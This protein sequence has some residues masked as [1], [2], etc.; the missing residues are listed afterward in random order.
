MSGN[1]F[2]I[3][4][5]TEIYIYIYLVYINIFFQILNTLILHVKKNIR[6]DISYFKAEPFFSRLSILLTYAPIRA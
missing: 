5:R 4:F 1:F 2:L 6:L 3:D